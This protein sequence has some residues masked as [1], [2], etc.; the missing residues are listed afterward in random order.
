[1]KVPH[2]YHPTSVMVVNKDGYLK[3]HM[4]S[5]SP[6]RRQ[7][8]EVVFARNGAAIYITR[9]GAV[10]HFIFG[11]RLIPFHMLEEDSIDI[12]EEMD[13]DVAERYLAA[14]ISSKF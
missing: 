7:E 10:E 1:M 3:P 14:R 6:T 8:K 4:N 2:I 12:D 11:G 9:L 5:T 13:F